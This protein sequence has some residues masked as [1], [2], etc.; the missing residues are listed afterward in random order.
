MIHPGTP[1]YVSVVLAHVLVISLISGFVSL[2]IYTSTYH[3]FNMRVVKITRLRH[4][5]L[6]SVFIL[7]VELYRM[8]TRLLAFPNLFPRHTS[9]NNSP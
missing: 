3:L 6:F 7:F 4:H 2:T 8:R 1:N 5:L 9:L